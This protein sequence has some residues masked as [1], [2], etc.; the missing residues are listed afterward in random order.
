MKLYQVNCKGLRP[1]YTEGRLDA[2]RVYYALQK[3]TNKCSM[4]RIDFAKML[5]KVYYKG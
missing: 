4:R 3:M 5:Y 2:L 1:Y